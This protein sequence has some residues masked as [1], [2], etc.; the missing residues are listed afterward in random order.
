V[1]GE[2]RAEQER[3]QN[4]AA[5]LRTMLTMP[6]ADAIGAACSYLLHCVYAHPDVLRRVMNE[7]VV[8]Q[9]FRGEALIRVI[10]RACR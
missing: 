2:A 8:R 1:S 3:L 6:V 4:Q 5:L 10:Q 9:G 7:P